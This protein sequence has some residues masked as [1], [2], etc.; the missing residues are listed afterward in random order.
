MALCCV[1]SQ[2]TILELLNI[3]H[4]SKFVFSGIFTALLN[5]SV[6]AYQN[7]WSCESG[8]I[9]TDLVPVLGSYGS[10]KICED[11]ERLGELGSALDIWSLSRAVWI[12]FE[13]SFLPQ[14]GIR[15]P[16]IWTVMHERT[17]RGLTSRAP[18][19]TSE[20]FPNALCAFRAMFAELLLLW[21][22]A[23]RSRHSKMW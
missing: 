11:S 20:D 8:E 15:L 18:D 12:L 1:T 13:H 3:I 2:A 10:Q 22:K 23:T 7:H 16:D 17:S 21:R 14:M 5:S 19:E 4:T 6:L 9:G